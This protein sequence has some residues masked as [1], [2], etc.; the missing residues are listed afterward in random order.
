M[1]WAHIVRSVNLANALS[2]A[3]KKPSFIINEDESSSKRL[4]MEGF[5]FIAKSFDTDFTQGSLDFLNGAKLMILDTKRD[6]SR[7]VKILRA[8][9]VKVVL[10][11]NTSAAAKFADLIIIPSVHPLKVPESID[12][13]KVFSGQEYLMLGENFTHSGDHSN[14][15]FAT[16]LRVLVTFGGADPNGLTCVVVD[17]LSSLRDLDITVVI[18]DAFSKRDAYSYSKRC[19]NVHCVSGLTDLATLMKEN[20]IAFTANGTSIYELAFTGT[21]SIVIANYE[22][23]LKEL[24]AYE[25]LGLSI[26]LG[27]FSNLTPRAIRSALGRFTNK[28]FFEESSKKALSLTDGLGVKRAGELI[29]SLLKSVK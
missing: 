2:K 17:A 21:P 25:A 5:T 4:L 23:D 6:V 3:D 28:E 24:D 14:A 22:S 11:D 27:L 29:V 9:E 13:K 7:I 1:G 10:I 16:P 26:G 18:G 12:R 15:A 19:D 8:K 20:H